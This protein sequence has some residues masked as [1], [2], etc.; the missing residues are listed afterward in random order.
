MISSAED[1]LI[2]DFAE[3]YHIYDYRSLPVDY[4]AT[5]ACGLREDSRTFVALN[6][7]KHGF[8]MMYKTLVL[9]YLARLW[10]AK[11]ED[12]QKGQNAPESIF[13]TVFGEDKPKNLQSFRSGD[14]FMAKWQTLT[15]KNEA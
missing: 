3:Y 7:T 11:T 12:G 14:D 1:A 13:K 15:Q 5:L 8:D 4:A 10:W 2:C 6:E 9:D